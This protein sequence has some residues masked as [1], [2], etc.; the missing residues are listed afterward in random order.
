[1]RDFDKLSHK[2]DIF[3]KPFPAGLWELCGRGGRNILRARGDGGIKETVFFKHSRTDAHMNSQRPWWHTQGLHKFKP[4]GVIVLRV[5]GQKTNSVLV[6]VDFL[7]Q[8]ALLG[9]LFFSFYWPF[10]CVL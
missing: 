3:I 4:D 2:W 5:D 10:A 7:P 1:M 6:F 9:S 8:T